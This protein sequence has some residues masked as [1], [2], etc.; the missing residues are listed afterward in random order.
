MYRRTVRGE[1]AIPSFSLS[2]AA[3]RSS[4]QVQFAAAI[5]AI[6]RRSSGGIR[7]GPRWQRLPPPEQAAALPVPPNGRVWV[8]GPEKAAPVPES[9]EEDERDPPGSVGPPRRHPPR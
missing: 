9:G 7:G 6:S 4:P 5:S 2:S 8:D 3:M 1:T